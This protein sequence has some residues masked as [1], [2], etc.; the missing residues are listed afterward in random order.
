MDRTPVESSNIKSVGYDQD[1]ETLEI[2]FV[3]GAIYE[4]PG[5]P[6][7][8]HDGLMSAGSHGRYFAS[9]IKDRYDGRRI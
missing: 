1:T 8:V 3:S 2:E 6:P 5:V 9:E 4:Y 7:S